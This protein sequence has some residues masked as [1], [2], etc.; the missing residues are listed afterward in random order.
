MLTNNHKPRAKELQ[1]NNNISFPIGTVLAVG[2][3]YQKL[4][5][6]TIFSKFKG[7]GIDIN[8][9]LQLLIAYKLTEN[10]SCRVTR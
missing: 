4:D 5:L 8:K 7:R 1:P 6:E 9:L 3:Y 10:L 2:K